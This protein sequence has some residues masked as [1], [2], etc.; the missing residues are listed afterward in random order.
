MV[1]TTRTK[2][3]KLPKKVEVA[4]ESATAPKKRS[5]TKSKAKA[6]TSKPRDKKVASGRVEKKKAPTKPKTVTKEKAPAKK[7]TD[8]VAGKVE[9]AKGKSGKKVCF[10]SLLGIYRRSV[11]DIVM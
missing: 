2:T 8:K 1:A 4:V 7:V 11:L 9:E 5:T 10:R 6:N 3:N